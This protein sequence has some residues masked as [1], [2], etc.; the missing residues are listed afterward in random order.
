[1]NAYVIRVAS[2]A[3]ASVASFSSKAAQAALDGYEALRQEL[4]NIR[5]GVV[6]DTALHAGKTVLNGADDIRDWFW[7]EGRV[8]V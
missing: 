4:A 6:L 1:M 5:D 3:G 7:R 2:A 8:K